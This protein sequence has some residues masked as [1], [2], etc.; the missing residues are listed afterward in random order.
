MKLVKYSTSLIIFLVLLCGVSTVQAKAQRSIQDLT[1]AKTSNAI[2][3]QIPNG[4]QDKI[5]QVPSNPSTIY[6]NAKVTSDLNKHSVG[7]GI[8]QTFLMGDFADLA[9]DSITLDAFYSYSASY[10]FDMLVNGHYSSHKFDNKRV[11]IPGL[12]IGIKGKLYNF[13]SFAPFV[14]GGFGF[15][16]PSVRREVDGALVD[17]KKKITFGYQF[18]AGVDLKLNSN[19]TIGALAHVHNPFDVKQEVGPDVEGSYF[20]ILITGMYTF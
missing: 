20:K 10:S 2:N 19:F 8:G 9:D 18:G 6:P 17:S 3:D 12:T 1:S 13:D 7:F 4:E 11:T 15:Y 16:Q 14:T 5:A